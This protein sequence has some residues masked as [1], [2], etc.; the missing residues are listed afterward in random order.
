[1]LW[2]NVVLQAVLAYTISA[3]ISI[4]DSGIGFIQEDD[5]AIIFYITV[6]NICKDDLDLYVNMVK[7]CETLDPDDIDCSSM[8][9]IG[10]D[11]G[12]LPSKN[13]KN[14]TLIYPNLYV[15]NRRGVCSIKISYRSE[16]KKKELI[17][18]VKFD[19]RV[20]NFKCESNDLDFR[21]NCNPVDCLIKYSGLI[22]YFNADCKKCRKVPKCTSYS[23]FTNECIDQKRKIAKEDLENLQTKQSNINQ[24][25]KLNAICHYGN[26]TEDGQCICNE[27]WTSNTEDEE[28]Y[29]PNVGQIHLCN[30]QIGDWSC[31]NKKR[32]R[33]TIILIALFAITVISK[34][35][36][37]M[38]VMTWCYKH[39][40]QPEPE[41]A[42]PIGSDD[43]MILCNKLDKEDKCKCCQHNDEIAGKMNA[44]H[45]QIVNVSYYAAS[46][47]MIS[48]SPGN[49]TSKNKSSTSMSISF[50]Y[51]DNTSPTEESVN[52]ETVSHKNENTG[53]KISYGV[54]CDMN[55]ETDEEIEFEEEEE[56]DIDVDEEEDS[57]DTTEDK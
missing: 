24:L 47:S 49:T 16:L 10:G 40:R 44:L 1:M 41:K 45:S 17:T 21:K 50:S 48:S 33:I 19:T 37:L 29:E 15:F 25:M 55:E 23:P 43:L 28:I 26:V 14:L 52:E 8:T 18:D 34:I 22:S 12:V 30:I 35:L 13:V 39:F 38:C 31:I 11:M 20:R 2:I 9:L 6:K 32:L 56:K 42:T 57:I 46:P 36:L 4:I 54:F 5:I 27:E 7:C 3:E 51:S 53:N